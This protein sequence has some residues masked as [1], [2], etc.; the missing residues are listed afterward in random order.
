MA[1]QDRDPKWVARYGDSDRLTIQYG[2]VGECTPLVLIA[3]ESWFSR[4]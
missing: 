2:L 4:R 1:E 3:Q